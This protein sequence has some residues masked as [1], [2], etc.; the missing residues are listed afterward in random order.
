MTPA[1]L[2]FGDPRT[3]HPSRASKSRRAAFLRSAPGPPPL[4]V[5]PAASAAGEVQVARRPRLTP[6]KQTRR[7]SR[8]T[9]AG[10][11]SAF[12]RALVGS[13]EAV[14]SEVRAAE[15][16]RLAPRS[17]SP[18]GG[19]RDDDE[20]G[21]VRRARRQAARHAP[22]D[23]HSVF[24]AVAQTLQARRGYT[25]KGSPAAARCSSSPGRIRAPRPARPARPLRT[26][27]S[28]PFL[29]PLSFLPFECLSAKGAPAR[30]K[31]L[32]RPGGRHPRDG[33][34]WGGAGVRSAARPPYPAGKLRGRVR[35]SRGGG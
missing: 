30:C 22:C 26:L 20:A 4:R 16:P 33:V 11:G 21:K 32:S 23:R 12:S 31:V 5:F 25:T 2:P 15:V 34:L 8:P 35:S 10:Q 14:R 9:A 28:S 7:R 18:G 24:S 27:P 17:L 19:A 1:A 6:H 29:G 13:W 3:R